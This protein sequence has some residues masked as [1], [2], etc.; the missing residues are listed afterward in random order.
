MTPKERLLTAMRHGV[1]DRVPATP[2][3]S[4][5]IPARLTGKPFW[6]IYLYQ[7][8]PLWLAYIEAV[9][10]FHIDG[11]LDYQ[12]WV[13]FPD[14]MPA[15]PDPNPWQQAI[16]EKNDYR[17]ITRA[18]RY[19]DDGGME[20]AQDVTV[21]PCYDPPTGG[22][23]LWK[24]GQPDV[25]DHW[26][27]VH[28]IKYWPTDESLFTMAYEMLGDRGVLGACCGTSCVAYGEAGVYQYYDDP[29]AVRESSRQLIEASRRRFD[30]LMK[31]KTRP[32]YITCGASGT[33][34]WQ[35]VEMF[36]DVSLP[37]VQAVTSWCREAGM[38]S[39]IHSCGPERELVRI[40]AEET[41]LD[42]IDPLEVPPMGDCDLAELKR[43]YGKRLCL[44]GNLHTTKT[45]LH[46]SYTDVLEASRKA[47]EDAREG[48]G[49]ILSTGDQCGRDTPDANI[50]AMIDVC[51]RYGRY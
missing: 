43:L 2:D 6:D 31:M 39:H 23:Q 50:Q 25:P 38:I 12:V 30:N 4:N 36:R 28:G 33:L 47:I 20:W 35:N 3:I 24:V 21:Y 7:D 13:T 22:V 17:L 1:P 49:F 34:I 16:V 8:P 32:D 19:R 14:E 41:E 5:M 27:P 37:V 42:V 45:M 40:C 11:F 51:E 44:K 15:E 10:H 18:Y 48:G 9:K 26:E 46:G 29:E